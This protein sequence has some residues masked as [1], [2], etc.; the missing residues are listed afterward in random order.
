MTERT[1]QDIPEGKLSEADQQPF[2]I[3][4]GWSDGIT[5]NDLLQSK[6][7]LL[8]SEA[9]TGK[10]HE[11]KQQAERLWN[12]GKPAFFIELASLASLDLP[13]LLDD[14]AKRVEELVGDSVAL[15]IHI[16]ELR[17]TNPR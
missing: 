12:E 8:V 7:I 2:L 9:G 5:W 6:R 17:T 4:M 13:S 14:E 16:L 11:C 1:F 3:D 10:T 15:V